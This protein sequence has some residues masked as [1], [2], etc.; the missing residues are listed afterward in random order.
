M[1]YYLKLRSS[2]LNNINNKKGSYYVDSIIARICFQFCWND[3][4]GIFIFYF[5][6]PFL[7]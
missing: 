1:Y 3:G 2:D 4:L 5:N 6:I 7:Y